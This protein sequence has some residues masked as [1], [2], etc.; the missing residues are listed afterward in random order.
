MPQFTFTP[1]SGNP[2]WQSWDMEVYRET[3]ASVL[4]D[5]TF[6]TG[7]ADGFVLNFGVA[8]A[9]FSGSGLGYSFDAF[10][11]PSAITTGMITGLTVALPGGATVLSITGLSIEGTEFIRAL[12]TGDSLGLVNMMIAGNDRITAGSGTDRLV[13]HLGNDT[14]DGGNGNDWLFGEAGADRLIGGGGADQLTGGRR[15]RCDHGRQ[16]ARQLR[17]PVCDRHVR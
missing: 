14:I 8:V 3:F 16:R 15:A 5:S 10:G 13:G 9:W 7:T 1:Q 11:N 6:V 17:L 12:V 4:L 2:L